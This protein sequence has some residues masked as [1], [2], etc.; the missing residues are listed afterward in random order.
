LIV[1]SS[2]KEIES[3]TFNGNYNQNTFSILIYCTP[4]GKIMFISNPFWGSLN[5]LNTFQ[6]TRIDSSLYE[7]E[8]ILFDL[9]FYG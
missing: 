5:S 6:R 3:G 7:N 1:K 9:G 2:N 4:L 8:F